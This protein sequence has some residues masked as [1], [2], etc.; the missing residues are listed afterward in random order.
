[1]IPVR[2]SPELV[3]AI[4][5]VARKLRISRSECVRQWIQEGLKRAKA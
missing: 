1:L 4:D 5:K 2:V 3:A